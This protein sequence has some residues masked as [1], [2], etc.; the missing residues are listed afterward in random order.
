LAGDYARAALGMALT[1]PPLLVLEPT[2]AIGILFAILAALCAFFLLRTAERHRSLISLED[3]RIALSG[4]R[5]AAIDW[6]DLKEMKLAYYSVARDRKDGWMQL[7]LSDGRV[8]I[9]IDSRL[10]GFLS[11]V[12]RAARAAGEAELPLGAV[13][14]ANLAA[15]RVGFD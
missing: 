15:L 14:R 10:D 2:M 12:R 5:P 8:T 1:L 6:R 7:S 11:V 4:L 3:E 13:T 9:K